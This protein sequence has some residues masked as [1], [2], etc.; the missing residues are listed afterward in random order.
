MP[1]RPELTYL[2]YI[3]IQDGLNLVGDPQGLTHRY[4]YG[5]RRDTVAN[6]VKIDIVPF[7]AIQS[8]VV[9]ATTGPVDY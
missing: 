3:N 7:P 6:A 9:R 8:C 2:R 5:T 4:L 1:E